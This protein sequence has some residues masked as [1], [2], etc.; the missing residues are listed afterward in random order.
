MRTPL[1]RLA[2]ALALAT[3]S[4]SS[5]NAAGP[6]PT[7]APPGAELDALPAEAPLDPLP[8]GA[9]LR[10]GSD[11][12]AQPQGVTQ[13]ALSEDGRRVLTDDRKTH[14]LTQWDVA[15][16]RRLGSAA[17]DA[18]GN[19][20]A[21][22]VA[23]GGA[24]VAVAYPDAVVLVD[25]SGAS[26]GV[27]IKVTDI[28]GVAWS[29]DGKRLAIGRRGG[30]VDLVDAATGKLQRSL[31]G[32]DEMFEVVAFSPDGARVAATGSPDGKTMIWDAASGKAL[33]AWF[34]KDLGYG[35]ALAWLGDGTL[36]VSLGEGNAVTFTPGAKA[37]TS[38]WNRGLGI[39]S[40]AATADS[41]V[42][43]GHYGGGVVV[44]EPAT[45][46]VVRELVAQSPKGAEGSRYAA[47]LAVAAG[48]V[49]IAWSNGSAGVRE[50][51]GRPATEAG[52]GHTAAVR[53]VAWSSDGRWLA[54]GD[55]EGTT[56]LWRA[57]NGRQWR[58]LRPTLD[59]PKWALGAPVRD[60]AV[61]PGGT[62]VAVA[63]EDKR[64]RV[65][66]AASGALVAALELGALPNAVAFSPDG[67]LLA[68][69]EQGGDADFI[70]VPTWGPKAL[71]HHPST[72]FDLGFTGSGGA[73]VAL[74]NVLAIW[75]L[76]PQRVLGQRERPGI[77]ATMQALA[78]SADGQTVLTGGFGGVIDRWDLR[79]PSEDA[80]AASY[81]HADGDTPAAHPVSAIAMAS[82]GGFASGG[83][84]GEITVF[85][86]DGARLAH[87]TGHRGAI[88]GLAYAP[89]GK[90]LA[91]AS[92]DGTLL[93]WR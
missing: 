61:Q 43:L 38:Q 32:R 62:L 3:S 7:P 77:R 71:A 30:K 52:A 39:A 55:A 60:V 18:Q 37:P 5:A 23:P 57:A 65:W 78:V 56:L 6:A 80:P 58:V 79:Q 88:N 47:Q 84:D 4:L 74:D 33:L 83:F 54:S 12:L 29:P 16:G 25:E 75:A 40:L 72:V 90:A 66:D 9:S 63:Q 15:T 2:C 20:E 70:E 34:A 26:L 68:V 35:R 86:P 31:R 51:D 81:A 67:R 91:S 17:V 82:S 42:V 48:R 27:R 41:K 46:A 49:A 36:V 11:T 76:T 85:S 53:A 45:G 13:L 50:L 24:R 19:V 28:V 93:I 21:L 44:V 59:D 92:A 69:G 1:P 89:D 8:D 14:R 10:L 73:V 87:R 22:A 64:V